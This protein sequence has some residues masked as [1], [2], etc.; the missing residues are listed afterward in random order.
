[1][2]TSEKY[3]PVLIARFGL[4]S[5]L[6]ILV[7]IDQPVLVG[8]LLIPT[9]LFGVL[10]DWLA[11]RNPASGNALLT[12]L[13]SVGLIFSVLCWL[14]W[15]E[16]VLLA[17]YSAYVWIVVGAWLITLS[18]G[19]LRLQRL[20]RL[21]LHSSRIS[22]VF[23]AVFVVTTLITGQVI[24]TLLLLAVLSMTLSLLEESVILLMADE[25]DEDAIHGLWD[26][27]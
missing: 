25:I 23:Q 10:A 2:P 12:T 19:V 6:W 14:L 9:I 22:S 13:A 1:M 15:L 3:N 18:L 26:L 17:M 11:Q 20:V 27:R 7:C 16:P 21:R 5:L 24:P 4:I 8:W